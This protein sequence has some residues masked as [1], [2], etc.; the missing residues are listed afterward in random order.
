MRTK[1][2]R[3]PLYYRIEKVGRKNVII[4]DEDS[5]REY[6]ENLLSEYID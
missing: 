2:L 1:F 4:Y 6:F 3:I 5:I